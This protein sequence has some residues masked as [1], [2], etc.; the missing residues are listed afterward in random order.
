MR[1]MIA[2]DCMKGLGRETVGPRNTKR[3]VWAG[4]GGK[5][6]QKVVICWWS[7]I[8]VAVMEPVGWKLIS[9]LDWYW[10]METRNKCGPGLNNYWKNRLRC[11]L[12]V[13]DY[14]SFAILTF[15][16]ITRT[17]HSSESRSWRKPIGVVHTRHAQRLMKYQERKSW[18]P[19]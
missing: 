16:L 17:F 2:G 15:G 7:A 10:L 3:V 9:E 4:E 18:Y 19:D 5:D 13:G 8:K 14:S 1:L 12:E 6:C 11:W